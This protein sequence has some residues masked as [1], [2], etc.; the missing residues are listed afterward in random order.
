MKHSRKDIFI[1]GFALFSMFFGAGNAIFPPYLGM[2]S[3][4][5]WGLGFLCYYIVDIG[6]A[7]LALYSMFCKGGSDAIIKPIGRI[8]SIIFMC[9]IVLCIGPMLAIPR[10]AA[11]TFEMS[12]QP[13]TS[14][15]GSV[16]FSI[17]FFV[18]IF[19]CSIRENSVVDI[20]GK[21][22]TPLLLL[23]LMILIIKGMISPLGDYSA[24]PQVPNVAE[25]GIKA[26][27]QTMDV[28]AT[29]LFG[30]LILRSTES[31]GY[32]NEHDR[33]KVAVKS[34]IIAGILLMIVYSGLTY[35]GATVSTMFDPSIGRSAL[36]LSI[37][38]RLLG[39]KG[40][41]LFAT[42]VALACIT[43]AVGLVSS[44]SEYFADLCHH[45]VSYSAFVVII[46]VF[47]AVVS[48]FGL[49]QI[50]SIS[51]PILD[52]VYPPALVLIFLSF[53]PNL[54][55]LTCKLATLGALAFSILTA[56]SS[57]GG[58]AIPFL[59]KLPFAVFGFGWVLPALICGLIGEI[60]RRTV[61][62]VPKNEG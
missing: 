8:S 53:V 51:A 32:V 28:L 15:I 62:R 36:M 29:M 38:T 30:T 40:T 11:M 45:K 34:S 6:L 16:L 13:L 10:T 26:G 58:V 31:K 27:Y 56:I 33:K 18:I 48:N 9:A 2:G 49:E 54:S 22:L 17:I 46:C 19:V 24:M 5:Q 43:T 57:Y 52:I 25:S 12:V 7:L 4:P 23:G 35:L 14:H 3:G 47:S 59:G 20:V 44:C 1:I 50:V 60:L 37:V 41:I 39:Q 55:N 42:V 21:I 61:V